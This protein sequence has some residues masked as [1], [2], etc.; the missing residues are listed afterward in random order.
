MIFDGMWKWELKKQSMAIWF[1]QK[2]FMLD[3]FAE[4]QLTKTVLYSAI[5]IRK[6]IEDSF[7]FNAF[8]KKNNYNVDKERI[9]EA[10]LQGTKY[11]FVGDEEW[12]VREKVFPSEY[13]TGKKVKI[14]SKDVCNWIVHSYCWAVVKSDESKKYSGFLI[15]SDFDK[16]KYI[17]FV[18]FKEWNQF[19][20]L[21]IREA[22]I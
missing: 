20:E 10:N 5:V 13:D 11:A 19:I 9:L 22:C 1:W 8:A 14:N 15:A 18:P 17:H 6:V 21:V 2:F 7:E 3:N 12:Y 16:V 4:H